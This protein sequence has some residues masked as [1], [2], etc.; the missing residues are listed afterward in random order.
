M[1]DGGCVGHVPLQ[2]GFKADFAA[3]QRRCKALEAK[4]VTSMRE[5]QVDHEIVTATVRESEKRFATI[6]A[7]RDEAR[8]SVDKWC[9][10]ALNTRK[11]FDE[12]RAQVEAL[13]KERDKARLE[14]RAD[15]RALRVGL[16]ESEQQKKFWNMDAWH[17]ERYAKLEDDA[18]DLM[19]KLLTTNTETRKAEL[20]NKAAT[21]QVE[22]LAKAAKQTL[23]WLSKCVDSTEIRGRDIEQEAADLRDALGSLPATSNRNQKLEAVYEAAKAFFAPDEWDTCYRHD[24]PCETTCCPQSIAACSERR[25]IRA[26][27]EVE[28]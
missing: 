24:I 18:N 19:G 4:L 21:A 16:D 20:A 28:A 26:I 11:Q 17:K 7:E 14:A 6:R 1:T 12:A 3:L 23:G 22:L 8:E 15:R 27:E 25:L 2:I 13:T 5:R 10:D 9:A